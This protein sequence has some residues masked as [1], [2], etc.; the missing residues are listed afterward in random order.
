MTRRFSVTALLILFCMVAW[1]SPAQSMTFL[2]NVQVFLQNTTRNAKGFVSNTSNNVGKF[3]SNTK[4]NV[5]KFVDDKKQLYQ[6]VNTL[7]EGQKEADWF[8]DEY[9]PELEKGQKIRDDMSVVLSP[10]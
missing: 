5:T 4:T 9:K 7:R 3:A 2:D 1:L 8:Q 6:D 10:L